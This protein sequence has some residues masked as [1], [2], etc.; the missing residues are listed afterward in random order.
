MTTEE[1]LSNIDKKISLILTI[2]SGN[3]LDKNDKG[4][5]GKIA[6]HENRIG[7]IEDHH[8]KY[9]HTL[10]GMGIASGVGIYAIIK[11]IFFIL[12]SAMLLSIFLSCTVTKKAHKSTVQ[13]TKTSIADSGN[14]SKNT[15]SKITES[16]WWK[17]TFV[18][19]QAAKD[20]TINN[21]YNP[22]SPMPQ[23]SIIYLEGGKNK[24]QASSTSS[25]SNWQKL[26]TA[27][28]NLQQTKDTEKK[29]TAFSFWQIIALSFMLWLIVATVLFAL[30]FYLKTK[31]KP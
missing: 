24:E 21:F 13:Q 25:D 11:K 30:L 18:F 16:D 28:L 23:P 29:S 1:Q 6:S 27:I 26:N 7:K 4:I 31:P 10:L 12:T 17:S 5:L 14:V 9:K 3:E 20:C 19:P 2:I 8:E 22:A 15:N